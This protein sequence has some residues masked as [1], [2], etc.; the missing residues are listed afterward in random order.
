MLTILDILTIPLIL[1]IFTCL[2]VHLILLILTIL[3]VLAILTI[4]TILMEKA[5]GVPRATRWQK[6]MSLIMGTASERS[7]RAAR[8]GEPSRM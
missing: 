4:H 6:T 7:A 2:S 1:L 3:T 5:S 8:L